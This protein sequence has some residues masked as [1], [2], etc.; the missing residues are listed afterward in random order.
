MQRY[1]HHHHRH[2]E[3]DADDPPSR[4]GLLNA[5]AGQPADGAISGEDDDDHIKTQAVAVAGAQGVVAAKGW[6]A[7][8]KQQLFA[9]C[10][11]E[12]QRQL[13][14][15]RL[16]QGPRTSSQRLGLKTEQKAPPAASAAPAAAAA[17][18]ADDGTTFLEDEDVIV[19]PI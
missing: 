12:M 13:R 9:E 19:T 11:E 5:S 7:W 8:Q 17:P 10:N 14:R 15:Q 4:P 18:A 2:L 6:P 3:D 1:H 16:W